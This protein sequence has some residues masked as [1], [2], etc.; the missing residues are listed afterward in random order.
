MPRA[1]ARDPDKISSVLDR[2]LQLVGPQHRGGRP[3]LRTS[4]A[5]AGCG[6]RRNRASRLGSRRRFRVSQKD[7]WY[8]CAICPGGFPIS[9]TL[10]V[11]NLGERHSTVRWA[12]AAPTV[13]WTAQ[14]AAPMSRPPQ[15]FASNPAFAWAKL[16]STSRSHRIMRGSTPTKVPCNSED[17]GR[18]VP[19]DVCWAGGCSTTEADMQLSSPRPRHMTTGWARKTIMLD[20]GCRADELLLL[21]Q[22]RLVSSYAVR[23]VSIGVSWPGAAGRRR[24]RGLWPRW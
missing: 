24:L 10:G 11:G 19:I 9:R 17:R 18:A 4:T 3:T 6:G 23:A 12:R 15:C 1:R 20:I 7:Y 21:E 16:A 13:A 8:G 22:L 14:Q 2:L 5:S